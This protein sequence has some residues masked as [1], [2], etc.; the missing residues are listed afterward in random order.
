MLN[1]IRIRTEKELKNYVK[2]LDKY[3]SLDK[4][5]ALLLKGIKDFV[6][7]PG[8]RLR[9]V[10]FV[11][12]Y[13]GFSKKQANG[14]YRSALSL[15]MFHDFML[16]HD[17]IIDKSS[18]RRGKPAMHTLFNNFLKKYR[19]AKFNGQDLAIVAGDIM[20]ALALD[21]FLSIKE[22][23]DRKEK[24]LKKLI[25]AALRTGSGEFGELLYGLKD[26]NRITKEDIYRIY[27]FKTAYYTFAYPLVMG[28]ILGGAKTKEINL[29]TRYGL[30]LGRA[31]QI[32]DDILGMFGKQKEIGKSILTDLKEVKKT[33]LVW[34]AYNNADRTT[35]EKMKDIFKIKNPGM[36][37]LSAMRQIMNETGALKY[38]KKEISRLQKEALS[39]LRGL[40]MKIK[41]KNILN[42][43]C[44]Q[45]LNA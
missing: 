28:A 18:L 29:L 36:A 35:Q 15:E 5:S 10:L 43:Y 44:K 9:P 45:I 3:R 21:A 25:E 24:A 17:D 7:R 37:Q 6:L 40:K 31:F 41:Y 14:L 38:A 19:E 4:S 42:A 34:Y 12:G 2:E 32:K 13:R 20:Y 23:A 27:D 33:L 8:K 26:I 1:K 30:C 39:I 22:E 11:V 16:V